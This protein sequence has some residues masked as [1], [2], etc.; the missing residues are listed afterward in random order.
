MDRTD[1]VRFR[2]STVLRWRTSLSSGAD[3]MTWEGSTFTVKDSIVHSGSMN[4]AKQQLQEA[5]HIQTK[6]HPNW[7]LMTRPWQGQHNFCWECGRVVV[8]RYGPEHK[9]VGFTLVALSYW[10]Q[11]C[12]HSE[13][14]CAGFWL[15]EQIW[16][17]GRR[18]TDDTGFNSASCC[19][20]LLPW[21]CFSVIMAGNCTKIWFCFTNWGELAQENQLDCAQRAVGILSNA[22]GPE[23]VE[24]L[25]LWNALG[26][27]ARFCRWPKGG[28]G[29]FGECSV[30][31]AFGR[32]EVCFCFAGFGGSFWRS[33]CSK[34]P[35]ICQEP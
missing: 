9:E 15:M 5:L 8:F 22:Y 14:S 11:M 20:A 24:T 27:F 16:R 3:Q 4:L 34:I 26:S 33:W 13:A 30:S 1:L 19:G 29:R 18:N 21:F 32:A 28:L 10:A 17:H 7:R 25:G 6:E 12:G 35:A 31:S 23:H 2:R